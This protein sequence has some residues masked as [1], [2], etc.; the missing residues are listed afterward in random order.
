MC[1]PQ[2]IFLQKSV[3]FPFLANKRTKEINLFEFKMVQNR[4]KLIKNGIK[5]FLYE[6][7]LRKRANKILI[8]RKLIDCWISSELSLFR[9]NKVVNFVP[10]RNG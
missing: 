2:D 5:L 10:C 7:V 6:H 1:V 8:S 3:K 9:D 4:E